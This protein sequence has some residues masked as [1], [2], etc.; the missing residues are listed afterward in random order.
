[1]APGVRRLERQP[2]CES[3]VN[4][5]LKSVVSRV[6][7]R[8]ASGD[9]P[10]TLVNPVCRNYRGNIGARERS[11]G[12]GLAGARHNVVVGYASP[13]QV[14]PV[15]PDIR[16]LHHRVLHDL[17]GNSYIPLPALWRTEVG[18][19]RIERGVRTHTGDGILQR[20][21]NRV[22]TSANRTVGKVDGPPLPAGVD[23]RGPRWVVGHAQ[24]VFDN[25]GTSHVAS[26]SG[27]NCS[28]AVSLDIPCN[29]NTRLEPG[30]VCVDQ[31]SR[32]SG[33]I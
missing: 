6:A 29:A 21:P 4:P 8:L 3:P 13:P 26:K 9:R 17:S 28:L 33:R 16:G 19:D 25:V 10:E 31:R 20:W 2:V 22:Q 27:S 7:R 1:M 5:D 18:V 24:N 14:Q 12:D 11:L 15:V 32:Q 30:I 23:R